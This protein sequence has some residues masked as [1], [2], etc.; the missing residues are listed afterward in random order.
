MPGRKFKYKA[1]VLLLISMVL[2]I[3]AILLRQEG[4]LRDMDLFFLVV[5]TA[6]VITRLFAIL[7]PK[8]GYKPTREELEK[9]VFD[10]KN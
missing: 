4:K 5:A 1:D 3:T 9:N 7:L 2:I 6:V 8:S 10:D